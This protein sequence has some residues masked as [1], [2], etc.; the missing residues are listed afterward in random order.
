MCSVKSISDV[1]YIFY[2]GF[3]IND[4]QDI[5]MWYKSYLSVLHKQDFN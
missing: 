4:K 2:D 1:C 5:A 3:T